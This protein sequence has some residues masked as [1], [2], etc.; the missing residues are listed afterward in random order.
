M[1]LF[2]IVEGIDVS[3]RC[4]YWRRRAQ[5]RTL[6]QT[7]FHGCRACWHESCQHTRLELIQINVHVYIRD[8]D[9]TWR[10]NVT[11]KQQRLRLCV[12]ATASGDTNPTPFPGRSNHHG[13]AKGPQHY[14]HSLKITHFCYRGAILMYHFLHFLNR[15]KNEVRKN[16]LGDWRGPRS[17][18]FP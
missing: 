10:V 4:N 16:F 12:S 17:P 3:V 18:R 5:T 9:V 13:D 2:V 1:R 14:I 15:A 6:L 11:V 8:S 7:A